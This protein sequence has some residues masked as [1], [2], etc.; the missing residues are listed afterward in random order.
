MICLVG[1][2]QV[3]QEQKLGEVGSQ[4]VIWWH[5]VSQIFTP[6]IIRIWRPFLKLQSKMLAM[7]FWDTVYY[8]VQQ[9]KVAP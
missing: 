3:V 4:M 8:R 7:F 5:V 1:F 9:K 2:P 6:E